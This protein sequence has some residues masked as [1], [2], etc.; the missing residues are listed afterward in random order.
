MRKGLEELLAAEPELRD[1]SLKSNAGLSTVGA[2]PPR[3]GV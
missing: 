1:Y 3:N 2:M